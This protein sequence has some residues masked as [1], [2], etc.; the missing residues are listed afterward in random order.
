LAHHEKF[1][2]HHLPNECPLEPSVRKNIWTILFLNKKKK[3]SKRYIK[4][5]DIQMEA[6]LLKITETSNRRIWSD[7]ISGQPSPT[8][9][10]LS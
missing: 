7:A 9:N 6:T 3:T 5:T 10:K 1:Q 2:D 8:P 4:P